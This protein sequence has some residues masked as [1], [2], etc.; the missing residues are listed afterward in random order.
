MNKSISIMWCLSIISDLGTCDTVKKGGCQHNCTA[1]TGG[2]YICT[3]PS[4]YK[5]NHDDAKQC[6]GKN[7][8]YLI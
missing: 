8:F 5:V 2:G 7:H 1:L 6:I 4:G 3:C